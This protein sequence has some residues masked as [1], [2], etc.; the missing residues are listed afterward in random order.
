MM[1]KTYDELPFP[2]A[3]FYSDRLLGKHAGLSVTEIQETFDY[4]LKEEL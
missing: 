2:E 3:R 1:K 4:N